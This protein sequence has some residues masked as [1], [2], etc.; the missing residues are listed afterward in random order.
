MNLPEITEVQRLALRPGDR[1][2]VRS[3][4]RLDM[5]TA[6]RMKDRV[7][8][9]LGLPDGFPV[10]VMDGGMS[11]EAVGPA[12]E[13]IGYKIGGQLYHPADVQIVYGAGA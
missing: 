2:I 3:T 4:E 8:A 9:V 7:R 1:I 5:A 6:D 13:L 11:L 10:L 12:P